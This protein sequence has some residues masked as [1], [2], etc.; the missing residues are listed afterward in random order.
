[1]MNQADE[2]SAG[3]PATEGDQ[4]E[5]DLVMKGGVT[6]GVVYPSA[7][8]RLRHHYRF[9]SIGGTSAGAIA[10][11]A[12]AAAEYARRRGDLSGFEML[13]GLPAW[14]AA[15]VQGAFPGGTHSRLFSLFQPTPEAR[16]VYRVLLASTRPDGNKYVNMLKAVMRGFWLWGVLAG[17]PGG[18][19]AACAGY[20]MATQGVSWPLIA[21]VVPGV[22]VAFLGAFSGACLACVRRAGRALA[23]H[24]YGL[25]TG[26]DPA[27]RAGTPEALTDWLSRF[28]DGLAGAEF[29]KLGRPLTFGDLWGEG[30]DDD[31]ERTRPGASEPEIRLQMMTTNVTLS[32]PYRLPHF[33]RNFLFREEELRRYFPGPVVDWM[34]KASPVD[35]EDLNKFVADG[36]FP[37][38]PA[39]DL[40]VVFATRMSLALPIVLTAIPLYSEDL[41]ERDLAKIIAQQEDD[42]KKNHENGV[43]EPPREGSPGGEARP[44]PARKPKL[45]L[46]SDGGICS[47]FP[48]HF[49]DA[50]L[51]GRPTFAIN[52]TEFHEADKA[53]ELPVF[54]P[55]EN[56]GGHHPL[57]RKLDGTDGVKAS[58]SFLMACVDSARNWL[59]STQ[60]ELPGYRDRI[61]HVALDDA[62]EGGMNMDMPPDVIQALANRGR[63]AGDRLV[64]RFAKPHAD[65]KCGWDNHR[66]VRYRVIMALLEDMLGSIDRSL[67]APP[68]GGRTFEELHLRGA[69]EPPSSYRWQGGDQRDF[70][71]AQV[72]ELRKILKAWSEHWGDEQKADDRFWPHTDAKGR[73]GVPKPIPALR[74]QPRL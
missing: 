1:M 47:N 61:V 28:I 69:S 21:I 12:T 67:E 50:F 45:C 23:D 52:L 68:D 51:P 17:L 60:S 74:I 37:L 44:G 14:L 33:R 57:F 41:I 24:H 27:P 46:F 43:G 38:P 6:S 5:C 66:W 49:F 39:K 15:P 25:C 56:K 65:V 29:Q 31:P 9:R 35:N 22:F 64:G 32:R 53:K 19:I 30:I 62:T 72:A 36:Y 7:V 34:K 42:K 18:L 8:A 54:L 71:A 2:A 48:V 11:A 3:R 73:D 59:N 58:F 13:D 55:T 20:L 10:A 40:P 4:K 16:P 70:T 26:H 63:D